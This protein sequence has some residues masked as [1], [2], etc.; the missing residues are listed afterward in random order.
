MTVFVRQTKLTS[1]VGRADYITDPER[2]ENILMTSLPRDEMKAYFEPYRDYEINNRRHAKANNEGRELK[3]ALPNNAE[4]LPPDQLRALC[5]NTAAAAAGKSSD[6]QWSLHKTGNNLHMHVVFSERSRTQEV[7]V[8]D[9]DIWL[10][11]DGKVARAKKDRVELKHKKGEA[12]EGFTT[13]DKKYLSGEFLKTAKDEVYKSLVAHGFEVERHSKDPIKLRHIGSTKRGTTARQENDIKFNECA[14]LSNTLY[15][16]NLER[17]P[18][19]PGVAPEQKEK[20]LI[21]KMY[22]AC[23]AFLIHFV[24]PDGSRKDFELAEYKQMLEVAPV[25]PVKEKTVSEPVLKIAQNAPDLT[26]S[27]AAPETQ[28]KAPDIVK[29]AKIEPKTHIQ[30]QTAAVAAVI[31]SPEVRKIAPEQRKT[32]QPQVFE[33]VL[34]VKEKPAAPATSAPIA[35]AAPPELTRSQREYIEHIDN[36][37]ADRKQTIWKNERVVNAYK[38][39]DN[40]GNKEVYESWSR[41][42]DLPL[43]KFKTDYYKKNQGLIDEYKKAL[44]TVSSYEA[45]F[46][47]SRTPGELR[48]YAKVDLKTANKELEQLRK[49]RADTISRAGQKGRVEQL[50]DEREEERAPARER[51]QQKNRG[52]ITR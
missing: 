45:G 1:I 34:P 43:A 42:N 4:Q 3:I 49:D 15:R 23:K 24:Y 7:G 5:Q 50:L 8:W 38:F 26:L 14:A 35:K 25:M 32:E 28:P 22:E 30:E 37:I 41:K 39:I 9:R 10:D 11:K 21:R 52:D 12:K 40:K 19:S 46:G 2:Q 17:I 48:N 27:P 47:T 36:K 18:D 44:K 20:S 6:M 31:P 29:T 16:Q 51:V 33:P 13:K